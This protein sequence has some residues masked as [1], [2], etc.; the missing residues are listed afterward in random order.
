MGI[1]NKHD[2]PEVSSS[3]TTTIS[4]GAKVEGTFD[5]N[6]RLHIDGEIRGEVISKSVVTIGK[7]GKFFGKMQANRLILNGF[8]NGDVDCESAE[9]LSGSVFEGKITSRELIIEAKVHFF[10]ESVMKKDKED[11][12]EKLLELDEP[13]Q[14]D[15]FEE[16]KVDTDTSDL[17]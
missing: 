13:L 12:E 9:L 7:T 6:S 14:I 15:I 11:K 10:A 16:R 1:L 8:L 5:C 2:Q 17:L 4:S 3:E